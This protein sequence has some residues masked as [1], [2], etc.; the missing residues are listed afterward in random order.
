M[1]FFLLQPHNLP[2]QP[3]IIDIRGNA[4]KP[5][6]PNVANTLSV[7]LQFSEYRQALDNNNDRTIEI[8]AHENIVYK[9][10]MNILRDLEG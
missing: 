1:R 4:N 5:I 9:R 7:E 10:I 2:C 3:R 8:M 6:P